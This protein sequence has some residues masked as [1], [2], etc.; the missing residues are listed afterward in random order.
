MQHAILMAPSSNRVYTR[1]A[2]DLTRAE[3]AVFAATVLEAEVTDIE[4]VA[5]GNVTHVGFNADRLGERDLRLLSNLSSAYTIY[6]RAGEYLRPLPMSPRRKYP[7]D[8]VTI[9]RYA[10]KTNESFTKL[11]V[12]LA[13]LA[14]PRP[15]AL[16]DGKVSLLDPLCG[17][18]TTL[19]HALMYGF[20]T[21][22]IDVDRA[23][24]DAYTA[25]L[26]TWLRTHRYKHKAEVHPLRREKTT[27]GRRFTVEVGIDKE[28]YR[29]GDVDRLTVV[30]GDTRVARS[31]LARGSFDVLATDAPYGVQHGSRSGADRL[32]RHPY[33]LLEE[34]L[35]VWHEL[36]RPGGSLCLSWN[37]LVQPREGM[38]E[39]LGRHGFSVI[40]SAPP[41]AFAHRVDQAIVRDVV[42]ATRA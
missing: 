15:E 23:D 35:P 7:D 5:I 1:S 19:N 24:F 36:L 26:K 34:A 2:V 33:E 6:E 3:L 16:L 42:V 31:F 22:G 8:L 13:V 39:M 38:V 11:L 9:Q 28:A 20:D 40:T 29:A 37:V 17:R 4:P 18:G 27:L 30:Q 25:F 21:T 12:N 41:E 14:G 10:G 32:S